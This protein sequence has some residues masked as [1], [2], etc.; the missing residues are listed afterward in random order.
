MLYEKILSEEVK[1]G[2]GR[3]KIGIT[4]G[5]TP[6]NKQKNKQPNH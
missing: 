2:F 6:A 4:N 3:R 1:Q 5:I